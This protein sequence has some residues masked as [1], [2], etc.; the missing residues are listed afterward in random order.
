[1]YKSKLQELCQKKAWR[2]PEYNVTKKGQ[3]HNPSFEATV[4]V[5]GMSFQSQ[6]PAKSSKEAQNNAAH[7]AFLHFTAP[8][9]VDHGSSNAI[10]NFDGD[11]ANRRVQ[12]LEADRDSLVKE[13]ASICNNN[14]KFKDMQHFYKNVLQNYAQK[15]NLS[16]PVYYCE[17][18][19]PP[20]ASRFRCKVTINEKFYESL[21]FFPTIKEAEHAAARIA[22]LSLA[23]DTIEEE[24]SSLYKNLLQE[25]TQKEGCLLP[26]YTTTRSG[27]AHASMFVSVVEVKGETFTG[28]EAKTKKQ[29]E[30]LA[31]KVAYTKLKECKSNRCSVDITPA[32]CGPE[33]HVVSASHL[34]T[35]VNAV[36]QQ[37][38]GFEAGM[39]LNSSS[40]SRSDMQEDRVKVTFLDPVRPSSPILSEHPQPEDNLCI[41]N[42]LSKGLATTNPVDCSIIHPVEMSTLSCNRVIVHPRVPNM[43]FPAGSTVLPMSDDDWVAVKV[44]SEP[45]Q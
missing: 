32:Y 36:T 33:V 3:D 11:I 17:S 45:N 13:P 19:G 18:E 27:E 26:V 25:L 6:N 1:M 4:D 34:P 22:L 5:N 10:T 41:S 24:D 23:P 40:T 8:P 14:E 39:L 9:L 21:E 37:N 38:F 20:H 44:G 16:R 28:Q 12:Q 42:I 43:K 35:N 7:L 30:F 2:L 29:A 31:A 15:R